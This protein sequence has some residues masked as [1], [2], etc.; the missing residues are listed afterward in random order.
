MCWLRIYR[1]FMTWIKSSIMST[2]WTSCAPSPTLGRYDQWSVAVFITRFT[3]TSV[4]TRQC[5]KVNIQVTINFNKIISSKTLENAVIVARVAD[6]L[7]P[8]LH[9]CSPSH[10]TISK[11]RCFGYTRSIFK[12]NIPP[13]SARNAENEAAS[14]ARLSFITTTMAAFEVATCRTVDHVWST[15]V[16]R[17][18]SQFQK[19]AVL[20]THARSSNKIYDWKVH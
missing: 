19:F 16:C 14:L 20:A 17:A 2:S 3:I 8:K 18:M 11:F 10:G 6:Y 4:V 12:Q 13:E 9:I 7:T 1:Q 15:F 5:I